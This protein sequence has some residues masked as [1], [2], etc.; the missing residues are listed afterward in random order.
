MLQI[1]LA[2][3]SK[4]RRALL[5][6]LGLKFSAVSPHYPETY[7]EGEPVSRIVQRLA[8]AKAKAL[9]TQFPNALIIGSDQLACIDMHGETAKI[10]GKPHD[11]S[12]AFEYLTKLSGQQVYL[13]AGIALYD[14][15]HDYLQTDLEISTC[16]M[17]KLTT[18]QIQAYLDYEQ[19]FDVAAGLKIECSGLTLI[20]SIQSKDPN[21]LLGFPLIKLINMLQ[22]LGVAPLP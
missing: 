21:A 14:P 9:A 11:Y 13:V 17:R 12:T 15:Y 4:Y 3:S 19:P 8:G 7:A 6:K 1:V 20:E 16:K 10:L 18:R 22:A 2:S 5:A